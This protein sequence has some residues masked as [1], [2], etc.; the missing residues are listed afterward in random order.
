MMQAFACIDC[1][2]L[3]AGFIAP[4]NYGDLFKIK[5]TRSSRTDKGVHSLAT[6]RLGSIRSV[7]LLQISSCALS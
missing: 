5:W 7:P 3:Q 6:V 2:A 4:S 1:L